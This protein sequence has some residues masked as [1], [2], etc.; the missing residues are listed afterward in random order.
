MHLL[1]GLGNPGKKYK[2][3]RHNIG[4]MA[5]DSIIK[6][7]SGSVQKEKFNSLNSDTKVNNQRILMSKP[8]TYVNRSGEA[9]VKLINYHKIP[10]DKVLV[11]HDDL[12][13]NFGNIKIKNGGG[14]AGHNGLKSIVSHIGN[15]FTRIRIG[16][17]HPGSKELV[18]NYVLSNFSSNEMATLPSIF[19]YISNNIVSILSEKEKFSA[20]IPIHDVEISYN[21]NPIKKIFNLFKS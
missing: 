9:V 4:Y 16:I 10:N 17:G 8:Q 13:L 19:D 7:T 11:I 5:I 14:T 18:S 21:S 2:N 12:D 3:N 6:N 15:D 20:N 1:V